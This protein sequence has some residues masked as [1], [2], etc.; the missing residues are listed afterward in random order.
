MEGK[1]KRLFTLV[2]MPPPL[3]L[4]EGQQ[5]KFETELINEGKLQFIGLSVNS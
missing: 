3:N 1:F 4:L 5:E 2:N